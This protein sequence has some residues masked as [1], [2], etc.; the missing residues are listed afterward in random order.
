[1]DDY[2]Q[3]LNLKNRLDTSKF[4]GFVLV[5]ILVFVCYNWW[6]APIPNRWEIDFSVNRPQITEV[7][8]DPDGHWWNGTDGAKETTFAWATDSQGNVGWLAVDK[9]GNPKRGAIVL[10][11]P[12]YFPEG[13]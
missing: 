2:Q 5:A 12:D 13:Q 3:I 11:E 6:T 10:T 8:H 7:W 1:M 4:L 9:N